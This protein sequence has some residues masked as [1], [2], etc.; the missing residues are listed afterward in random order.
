[1]LFLTFVLKNL[2]RR[3]ARSA[4]TLLGVGIAVA[5]VVALTGIASG[6]ERSF[7][8]LYTERGVDLM[9]VRAGTTERLGSSLPEGV[10]PRIREL[11]GVR[12]V[13]AGLMDVI[14]FQQ[15]QLIGVP[16]QGWEPDSFMFKELTFL[17]GRPLGPGDRKKV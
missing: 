11:P 9:I 1:M 12:A 2:L 10:G 4:L 17:S 14:S 13:T 7:R 6:F 15:R 16:I 5:A 3:K 8:R